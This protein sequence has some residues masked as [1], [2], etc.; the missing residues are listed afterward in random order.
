MD[1]GVVG[2]RFDALRH[3]Y[4][5]KDFLNEPC[6][7]EGNECSSTKYDNWD[8]I[9]TIDQPENIDIIM[10]WREFMDNHTRSKNFPISR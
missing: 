1:R 7:K 4:E 5:N 10:E 2:F 8:H 6:L 9:Y 3:L